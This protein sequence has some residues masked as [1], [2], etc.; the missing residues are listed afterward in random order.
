MSAK[1][2]NDGGNSAIAVGDLLYYVDADTPVISKKA[3]GG[4]FFGIATSVLASSETG[5][6]KVMLTGAPGVSITVND[7]NTRSVSID[8]PSASA[9]DA[10]AILKSVFVAAEAITI[11]GV[12]FIPATVQA[13]ADTDSATLALRNIGAAGAGTDVIADYEQ[14]SGNDF[15]AHVPA[16]FGSAIINEAVTAGDVLAWHRTKVGTGVD[17]PAGQLVI[18]YEVG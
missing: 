11:T 1:A 18:E 3:T 17:S 13:G 2:V 9:A 7:Q 15:A 4:I 6:V 12:S 16:D 10:S 14:T 5:T 8:V